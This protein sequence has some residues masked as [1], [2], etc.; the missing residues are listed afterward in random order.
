[1]TATASTPARNALDPAVLDT[2][3]IEAADAQALAEKLIAL[4]GKRRRLFSARSKIF[5]TLPALAGNMRL[6][7]PRFGLQG[8][9]NFRVVAVDQNFEDGAVTYTVWG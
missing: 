7:Y 4:H 5:G 1:M 9:E 2:S 8:G 3:L 6:T